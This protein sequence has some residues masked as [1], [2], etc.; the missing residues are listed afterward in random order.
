MK[1]ILISLLFP[2]IVFADEV[3]T[4]NLLPQ[5]FTTG[6]NW[7]GD[8]N[9]NHGTGTLAT[10]HGDEVEHSGIS[11]ADDA[12]MSVSQI[13]NGWS[14]EFKANIWI[15]N[16]Y[17]S[18]VKMEQ[19]ITNSSGGSV[20]QSRVVSLDGCGSINCGAYTN[21]TDTHTQGANSSDDYN[22]KSKFTITVP[23]RTSGHY[24]SDIKQPSLKITY[25]EN[26]VSVE[27]VAEIASTIENIEE[28]IEVFEELDLSSEEFIEVVQTIDLPQEIIVETIDEIEELQLAEQ[29]IE[30]ELGFTGLD[31]IVEI[32]EQPIEIQEEPSILE[33]TV[34][35][36]E[37]MFEEIPTEEVVESTTE[38]SVE[39][40]SFKE[41]VA[42]DTQTEQEV[43]TNVEKD[44]TL[45]TGSEEISETSEGEEVARTDDGTVSSETG[46]GT[47]EEPV[48]EVS[49]G[50]EVVTDDSQGEVST[51]VSID[52][53]DV[54]EKVAQKIKD[55]DKQLQATQMIVAKIMQNNDAINTY[56]QVNNQIFNNQVIIDGGNLDEYMQRTYLDTRVLYAESSVG[57]KDSLQLYQDRID[58]AVANRIRAEEHLR[59]IRGY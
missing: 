4:S 37:E 30:E 40:S 35:L 2:L 17:D 7:S 19:T 52:V 5:T 1:K 54:S 29:Q 22:I 47:N 32:F 12:D 44:E 31:S 14:S 34:E 26:P 45:S 41:E 58:E 36:I 39:E 15:W 59:S 27:T 38:G 6:N 21:Y 24:G 57:Y 43:A 16:N 50:E 46:E 11:L 13:R 48:R 23:N 18:T 3:T 56:S 20:T 8:I 9:H 10:Y 53:A 33:E 51:T 42:D 25:E 55:V 28:A 49:T